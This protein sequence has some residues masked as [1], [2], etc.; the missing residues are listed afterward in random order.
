MSDLKKCENTKYL[1]L[2]SMIRAREAGMLTADK[3]ER[4]LT[5][6]GFAEACAVAADCGYPDMNGMSIREVEDTL[7]AHRRAEIEDIA[8]IVPDS[9]LVDLFRLKYDYHSAKVMV[10]SD[11][12]KK[13]LLSFEG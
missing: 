12:T 3:V 10:K 4:M 11:G 2:T 7:S 6:P 1:F 8:L 5:A 13:D 9:E